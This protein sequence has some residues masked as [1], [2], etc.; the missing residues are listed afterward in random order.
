MDKIVNGENLCDYGCGQIANYKFKNGKLCCSDLTSQCKCVRDKSGKSNK[1]KYISEDTINKRKETRKGKK[2]LIL[3][4]N[5]D[6]ELCK[7]GCNQVGK[8][9]QINSGK[10]CCSDHYSKCPV[11][12]EKTTKSNTG[13]IVSIETIN[14]QKESM[15]GIKPS[16][17]TKIKFSLA[18]K[19]IPV[20]N[21]I[22]L[23]KHD[24]GQ[25]GK[26]QYKNGKLCCSEF[27][28]QCPSIKSKNSKGNKGR[29][30]TQEHLDNLSGCNKGR[31]PSIET[32]IKIGL[33]NKGKTIRDD[34]KKKASELNKGVPKSEEFKLK[35][36]LTLDKI[37]TKYPFLLMAED[38]KENPITRKMFGRCKW[39]ECENSKEN[40]GWF[41][42]TKYQ[43]GWRIQSLYNGTGN[44]HY[45]YCSQTCKDDCPI[46]NSTNGDPFDKSKQK[47][48]Y[49]AKEYETWKWKVRE[50]QKEDNPT[51]PYNFC[52]I[53]HSEENLDIH[54]IIPVKMVAGYCVDPINGII[55]CEKH[56]YYYGHATGTECSTGALA[57]RIKCIPSSEL[58]VNELKYQ[59]IQ[60]S[61]TNNLESAKENLIELIKQE[62]SNST[63]TVENSEYNEEESLQEGII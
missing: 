3:K 29:S 18:K 36:S 32:R 50:N 61:S 17:E 2:Y 9:F 58:K 1:G 52:E 12:V 54:H 40:D 10:W 26:Y 47:L 27:T 8:Y 7:Y 56:H 39:H 48:P 53:C 6:L 57:N 20:E 63:L 5:I 42:L 28:S 15:K 19:L 43:I 31:S 22:I 59:E 55:L 38:I 37:E 11:I 51:K 45:F 60:S 23:C 16:D 33:G 13:R 21:N 25:I 49:T 44:H 35:L 24:C 30:F 41:E 46:Y 4:L 62:E 14:K 34:V